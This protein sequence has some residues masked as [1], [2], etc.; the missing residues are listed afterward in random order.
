VLVH[1]EPRAQDAM[2]EKLWQDQQLEV[3]IPAN[4]DSI[5]F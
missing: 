3:E 1:G 2:A 5:V 4:G